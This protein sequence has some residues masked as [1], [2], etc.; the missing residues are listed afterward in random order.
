MVLHQPSGPLGCPIDNQAAIELAGG[1][2]LI[3]G[4]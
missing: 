2:D 3:G 1:I 4:A